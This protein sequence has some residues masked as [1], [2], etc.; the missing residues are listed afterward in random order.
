MPNWSL[1]PN[2]FRS[3]HNE[4]YPFTFYR[5]LKNKNRMFLWVSMV[6]ELLVFLQATV[7]K[8]K[9]SN[10]KDSTPSNLP[11]K[12]LYFTLWNYDLAYHCYLVPISGA[13]VS[14]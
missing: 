8:M 12:V 9:P 7:G 6:L 4:N 3:L 5:M 10:D 11:P 14:I 2:R 1:L 13:F